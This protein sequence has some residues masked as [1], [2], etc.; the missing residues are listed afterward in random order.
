VEDAAKRGP[1]KAARGWKKILRMTSMTVIEIVV[2]T[3]SI[4]STEYFSAPE[5]AANMLLREET[6][7]SPNACFLKSKEREI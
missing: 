3:T 1:G 7:M 5:A 4:V 6:A 2:S